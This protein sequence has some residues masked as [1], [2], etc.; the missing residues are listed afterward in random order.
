MRTWDKRAYLVHARIAVCGESMRLSTLIGLQRGLKIF[1]GVQLCARLDEVCTTSR[2]DVLVISGSAAAAVPTQ[3]V[4]LLNTLGHPAVIV[5]NEQPGPSQSS[6]VSGIFLVDVGA[7]TDVGVAVTRAVAH[8]LRHRLA[9]EILAHSAGNSAARILV[10]ATLRERPPLTISE[11]AT[12]CGCDRTSAAHEWKMLHPSAMA[13][14]LKDAFDWVLLARVLLAKTP[15]IKW[16][17]ASESIGLPVGRSNRIAKR[18]TGH[19]LSHLL[20]SDDWRVTCPYRSVGDFG[21]QQKV[22]TPLA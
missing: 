2:L 22:R 17:A 19:V 11:A 12:F 8:S 4:V 16:S 3:L 20:D 15:D 18:L 7:R 13:D 6:H 10:A 21:S 5:M 1:H 14:R 9:N